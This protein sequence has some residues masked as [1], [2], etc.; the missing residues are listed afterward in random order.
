M[1]ALRA[2]LRRK[3]E[4]GQAL[5]ARVTAVEQN[6]AELALENAALKDVLADIWPEGADIDS[7]DQ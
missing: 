6:N 3:E 2:A 1:R 4:E 7:W 5:Q